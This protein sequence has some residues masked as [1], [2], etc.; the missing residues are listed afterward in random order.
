M[1]LLNAEENYGIRWKRRILCE[2][3]LFGLSHP[4][5]AFVGYQDIR[6]SFIIR[7]FREFG[8]AFPVL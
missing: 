5:S 2:F 8:D 4:Y 1:G 6:L 7:R 3:R